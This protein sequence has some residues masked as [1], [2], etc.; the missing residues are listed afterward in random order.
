MKCLK[1]LI[2]HIENKIT[3]H[4]NYYTCAGYFLITQI[5]HVVTLK[6]TPNIRKET[7][8]NGLISWLIISQAMAKQ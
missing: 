1:Y 5:I 7:N 4:C 8:T 2:N 3:T 6:T